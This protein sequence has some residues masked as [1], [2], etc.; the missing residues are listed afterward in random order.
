LVRY[1]VTLILENLITIHGKASEAL[2]RVG[3]GG[4]I[5]MNDGTAISG[6]TTGRGVEID[7]GTFTM[8]GG[9]ISGNASVWDDIYDGS[10]GGGVFVKSNGTFIMNR[11]T[12]SGNVGWGGSGVSVNG[13]FIMSG[14]N[15]SGNSGGFTG[16]GVWV[17]GGI[18][19]M[20]DG[21]ISGNNSGTNGGGVRLDNGTFTMTGGSI[22]G[23]SA[24]EI[25]P[26]YSSG[27]GILILGGTF[28]L[29]SPATK[30]SLSG[31]TRMLQNYNVVDSQIEI[32]GGIFRVNG[33]Q[34]NGY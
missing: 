26:E 28:N 2:L 17:N 12:I 25:T 18:F 8:N 31:N 16:G 24:G 5:V 27:G 13:T 23:N 11:G 7:G 4:T 20:T 32:T 19:T 9:I 14:G 29:N 30:A 33:L 1:G 15:I 10:I 6:N 22:S 21:F 34:E 3:H